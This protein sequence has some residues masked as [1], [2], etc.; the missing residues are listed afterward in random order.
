MFGV[1]LRR[2]PKDQFHCSP[3]VD[4]VRALTE[5]NKLATCDSLRARGS[6]DAARM[7]GDEV[8]TT[9]SFLASTDRTAD[10]SADAS[11]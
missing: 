9:L 3:V 11:G 10:P 6:V 7:L 4:T 2:Q 5:G 8:L 1:I